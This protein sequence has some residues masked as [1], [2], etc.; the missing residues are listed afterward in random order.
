M[1]HERMRSP[2][3]RGSRDLNPPA[4]SPRRNP[5]C[6]AFCMWLDQLNMCYFLSA[7]FV[8]VFCPVFYQAIECA[9]SHTEPP[10]NPVADLP[11]AD[12]TNPPCTLHAF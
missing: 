11:P 2:M 10:L 7:L 3:R 8:I 12:L 6:N 9:H 1:I 5:R 4:P